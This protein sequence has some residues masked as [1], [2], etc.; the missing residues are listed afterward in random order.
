MAPIC[1]S[2]YKESWTIQLK[3]HRNN[4]FQLLRIHGM[5]MISNWKYRLEP[6]S[7]G[8]NTYWGVS[9]PLFHLA[10]RSSWQ[11]CT[12]RTFAN[13]RGWKWKGWLKYDSLYIQIKLDNYSLPTWEMCGI[14]QN[15]IKLYPLCNTFQFTSK[16]QNLPHAWPAVYILLKTDSAL[17]S[18]KPTDLYTVS[19]CSFVNQ[20]DYTVQEYMAFRVHCPAILF[21]ARFCGAWG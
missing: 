6:R 4:L 13:T 7:S 11:T 12:Q 20:K 5:Y 14:L 16:S 3:Y 17:S 21:R 19:V 15:I 1:I 9:G 2:W 18:I 10:T 8:G